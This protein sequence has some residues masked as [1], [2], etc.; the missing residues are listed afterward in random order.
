MKRTTLFVALASAFSLSAFAHDQGQQSGAQSSQDEQSSSYQQ[1]ANDQQSQS[2]DVVRQVQQKLSENGQ[3]VQPDGKM[4]PQTQAALKQFQQQ[5]GIQPTGQIDQQTLAA[6]DIN[7]SGSSSTGGTA[8]PSQGSNSSGS[9]SNDM[10]SG[11]SG[12]SS[13]GGGSNQ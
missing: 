10:G 8:A 13:S 1:S 7:P 2:P 4:G 11:G 6:L 5:K 3:N 9:S 12:S